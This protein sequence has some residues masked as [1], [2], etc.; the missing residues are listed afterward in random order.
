MPLRY[1]LLCMSQHMH[2][3]HGVSLHNSGASSSTRAATVRAAAVH[4]AMVVC[5][6]FVER[7]LKRCELL[8]A[9]KLQPC[10][11]LRCM[12]QRRGE[13]DA[14][15]VHSGGVNAALVSRDGR[16]AV[17]LSKDCTARVWDLVS[18]TCRHVLV[19]ASTNASHVMAFCK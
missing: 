5:I 16:L 14:S 3:P 9:L 2:L 10:A 1:Q 17:T 4:V 6:C 12:L 13:R 18:G 8:Q 11:Q 7:L 19:G 15:R